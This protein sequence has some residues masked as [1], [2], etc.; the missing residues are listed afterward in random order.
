MKK[1]KNLFV[2]EGF[3]RAG[4][5]TLMNDLS[6]LNLN[7]TYVLKN[8]LTGLPKY[9]KE[10]GDFL[11]WLDR[12]ISNFINEINEA[13]KK[14][15]NVIV[16]R[17]IISDEV[18]S[19]LFNRKHTVINHIN[20]L[21]KNVEIYN[22]CLLF[23]NYEEYLKRVNKIGANIQYLEYEFNKINDLYINEL[24]KQKGIICFIY[25]NDLPSKILTSFLDYYGQIKS[26]S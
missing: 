9:D 23:S 13:F 19:N 21:N 14:Y 6:K 3:D 22:Y 5:D 26:I 11:I 1:T 17:L 12:F 20:K 15:D 8:D 7:N 25:G 2:I 24:K 10:Q 16:T 4:K 18:Y